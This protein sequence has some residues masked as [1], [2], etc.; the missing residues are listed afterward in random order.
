MSRSG[1]KVQFAGKRAWLPAAVPLA[2]W[3]LRRTKGLLLV[4]GLGV[5]AA[6][7]CVC[8]APLYTQVA[9]T[10]GLQEALDSTP[11]NASISIVSQDNIPS[12]DSLPPVTDS[13]SMYMPS[14]VRTHLDNGKLQMVTEA[15]TLPIYLKSPLAKDSKAL[16]DQLALEGTDIEAVKA[17]KHVTMLQG[18]LP[19]TRVK[20]YTDSDSTIEIAVSA[21]TASS[22][23]LTLASQLYTRVGTARS[24]NSQQAIWHVVPLKIV[25]I[26]R[27]MDGKD[28]FWHG[29]SLGKSNLSANSGPAGPFAY[30]AVVSNEELIS[31]LARFIPQED[32]PSHN[33]I[34]FQSNDISPVQ[35]PSHPLLDPLNIT[36]YY[37]LDV[38]AISNDQLGE[39][40]L[41]LHEFQYRRYPTDSM[42]LAYGLTKIHTFVP[43]D[44]LTN[45]QGQLAVSQVPALSLVIMI[46][47]LLLYFVTL[48]TSLLVERQAPALA[49]VRSRGGTRGQVFGA[50]L[51]QGIAVSLLAL[52]VGLL[53]TVPV[54]ALLGY[55]QLPA[56]DYAAISTVLSDWEHAILL[57]GDLGLLTVIVVVLALMIA[58]Y[59]ATALDVLS[60]RREVGRST[61]RPLWL[62]F[63]L[64]LIVVIIMIVGY[65]VSF[66]L[67]DSGT[68]DPQLRLTLLSPLV[69]ARAV[70]TIIAALLLFLRF[71]PY[72]LDWGSR[73]VT[74]RNRGVS[75]VLALAQLA[76]APRQS[77]RMALLFALA[78]AFALFALVFSASQFQRAS[79]QAANTVGADFSGTFFYQPDA[80][81]M[82]DQIHAYSRL[83]G[84]QG[85][86]VGYADKL[87]LG[88]QQTYVNFQAVDTDT[89][90]NVV[91]WP[92]HNAAQPL[93]ELMGLL[94]RGRTSEDHDQFVPAL[95]DQAMASDEH[96]SVGSNF[97]LSA[98]A[99]GTNLVPFKVAA[100]INYLP[101]VSTPGSVLVDLRSY[102]KLYNKLV[103]TVGSQPL[104]INQIWLRT[105]DDPTN[106]ARIRHE[107][108]K[109]DQLQLASFND[110]RQLTENLRR[111][112]LYI[113][114]IGILALGPLVALLL[115]LLGSLIA[116]WLQARDRLVNFAI[117]RALG[118]T[119]RNIAGIL[120]WEQAIV[121]A[122][123]IV[124]GAI[125]GAVLSWM[126]VPSL[127][128]TSAPNAQ[129]SL[130]QFYQAQSIPPVQIIVPTLLGVGLAILIV[131]CVL[132]LSMMLRVISRP[133]L[134]G[135][136]RINE[137]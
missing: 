5:L 2:W 22:M 121:Y 115:V 93:P 28:P 136:L 55:L 50:L 110:R 133:S 95:I 14:F 92:A 1:Q 125:F 68:L 111:E 69:M 49:I 127:V 89:Y 9:M 72:L 106:L 96:L 119:P 75:S 60:L 109:G 45:Y 25:G 6:V 77:L 85:V 61:R 63:R 7:I 52:L 103:N 19:D 131:V 116:S 38:H 24:A 80:T 17:G 8:V 58:I 124:L 31:T 129:S 46:F 66:Y 67:T 74:R 100:I 126:T 123:A 21:D 117:M 101:A 107:L 132:A 65:G 78:T 54:T 79:D 88:Q 34:E 134:A 76:R 59:Q 10:A 33:A 35:Q 81:A 112:P 23:N 64:D 16:Q 20:A 27:D 97:S 26:F 120:A 36:W 51:V 82:T 47:S 83:Q 42:L 104:P 99:D 18:R 86:T 57:V 11:G 90:K 48:I 70:C 122:V 41:Q 102:Q 94:A 137:D 87:N 118:A 114:L 4:V 128:F 73:W 53:L 3:Q 32:I 43:I 71:F 84:V 44:S 98:S 130:D 135:T 91:Y 15:T 39:L 113:Q 29:D 30:K 62:R 12:W 13:F 40:L 108:L 105:T 56:S 37:A